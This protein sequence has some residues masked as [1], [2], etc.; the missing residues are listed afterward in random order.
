[1]RILQPPNWP[2]PKGFSNGISAQGRLLFVA[3]QVGADAQGR[4]AGPGFV[5]QAAQSLRNIVTVLEEDGAEPA[6]LTRLTWFVTDVNEYL[7]N[8]KPLGR[9][10]RAIMGEHYPAMTLVG[11]AA[12]V[13]PGA[14]VEIEASAVVPTK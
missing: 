3:G 10:Y 8:L 4:I 12:L 14:K 5:E 2:P 1:M 6:H 11:V 7:A 9:E 13:V